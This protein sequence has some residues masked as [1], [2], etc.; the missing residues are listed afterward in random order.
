MFLLFHERNL[1]S[2]HAYKAFAV[3]HGVSRFAP[4]LVFVTRGR[5]LLSRVSM[6]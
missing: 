5:E 3:F 1:V 4:E 2:H 6:R